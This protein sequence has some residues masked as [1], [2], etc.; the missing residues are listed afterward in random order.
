MDSWHTILFVTNSAC[1]RF[2]AGS[3]GR[4]F[5]RFKT[6]LQPGHN[7]TTQ[8]RNLFAADS[9]LNRFGSRP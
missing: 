5:D 6:G 3:V 9:V 1:I 2:V 4:R 8:V 7:L